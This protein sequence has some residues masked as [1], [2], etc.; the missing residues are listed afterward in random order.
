ME[1]SRSAILGVTERGAVRLKGK[2]KMPLRPETRRRR[3]TT[4]PPRPGVAQIRA[5]RARS[6]P[7]AGGPAP[8]RRPLSG[9]LRAAWLVESSV[10]LAFRRV[11]F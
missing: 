8:P 11:I 1:P 5:W 4:H 7:P 10:F 3:K 2:G 6:L 9:S